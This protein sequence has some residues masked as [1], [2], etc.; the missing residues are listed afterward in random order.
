[1]RIV[2]Q[3]LWREHLYAGFD[4]SEFRLKEISFLGHIVSGEGISIDPKKVLAVRDWPTP[5][6]AKQVKQF[7]GLAGYYKR[8]VKDFSK[9]V[10]P[11]TKLTRKGEKFFLDG[12]VCYDI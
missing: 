1:L 6:I 10:V 3:T 11:L 4:K 5:K 8:F 9:L 2:L 12:E 7:V